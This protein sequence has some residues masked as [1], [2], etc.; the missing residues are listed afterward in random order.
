[1]RRKTALQESEKKTATLLIYYS[2]F[3]RVYEIYNH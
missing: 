3:T 2:D 1:M